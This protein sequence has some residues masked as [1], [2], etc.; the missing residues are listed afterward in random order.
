MFGFFRKAAA[1]SEEIVYIRFW[2]DKIIFYYY[3]SGVK[4][5]D[6]PILAIRK[7]GKKEIITAVGEEINDLKPEDTSIIRTPFKPFIMEPENFDLGAKVI[8]HLMQKGKNSKA[9]L[10]APK[11]IIHPDRTNISEMEEQ[12]YRE[13]AVSAGAREAVVYVGHTLQPDEIEGVMNAK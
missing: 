2:R 9:A 8:R 12:A 4:Y 3:P 13:L 1:L 5:K 7:K 11:V 10:I 6:E